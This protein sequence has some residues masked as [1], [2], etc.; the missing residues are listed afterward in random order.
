VPL[1]PPRTSINERDAVLRVLGNVPGNGACDAAAVQQIIGLPMA[2][3]RVALEQLRAGSFKS[4]RLV[5][6]Y[7]T[8]ST[9][10]WYL[11]EDDDECVMDVVRDSIYTILKEA[12]KPM[13]VASIGQKL[14]QVDRSFVDVPVVG[15]LLQMHGG[16]TLSGPIVARDASGLWYSTEGDTDEVSVGATEKVCE[17]LETFRE[18]FTKEGKRAFWH[19]EFGIAIDNIRDVLSKGQ[20]TEAS[21]CLQTAGV[22]PT[23]SEIDRRKESIRSLPSDPV[24]RLAVL[25]VVL[26]NLA[27]RTGE[28]HRPNFRIHEYGCT[29]EGATLRDAK[30][31][32]ASLIVKK[33]EV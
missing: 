22:F 27:V 18:R 3:I 28:D 30:R 24:S 16:N 23:K 6:L 5:H 19:S 17:I 1:P 10:R 9:G 4:R 32:L 21:G 14:I 12:Q 13:T 33:Y 11:A 15:T 2:T 7:G 26:G 29:G 20:D 25:G 31:D 8:P